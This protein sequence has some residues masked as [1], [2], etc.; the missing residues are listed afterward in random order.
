MHVP[1]PRV[2]KSVCSGQKLCK[3]CSWAG[4]GESTASDAAGAPY[5]CMQFV[6][7]SFWNTH[8]A[9]A[10]FHLVLQPV[11]PD[12]AYLSTQNSVTGGLD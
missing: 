4:I 2:H 3:G 7:I 11:V 12:S 9:L 6:R 5:M 1:V 10:R 8:F